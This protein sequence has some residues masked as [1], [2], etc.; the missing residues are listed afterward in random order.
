MAASQFLKSPGEKKYPNGLVN[1]LGFHKLSFFIF[2][3][4]SISTIMLDK[5]VFIGHSVS[6]MFKSLNQLQPN[7][8]SNRQDGDISPFTPPKPTKQVLSS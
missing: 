2:P 6:V 5:Q 1:Y 8:H 7:T 3:D 4:T